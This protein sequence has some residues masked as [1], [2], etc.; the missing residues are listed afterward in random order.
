MA[1]TCVQSVGTTSGQSSQT[2]FLAFS[3]N[4]TAGNLLIV[5]WR[6]GQACNSV[7]DTLGNS[8]TVVYDQ[9]DGSGTHGGWA[10]AFSG[11]SGANTVT[12]HLTASTAGNVIAVAEYNGPNTFRAASTVAIGST[13]SLVT[14][15][16]T[17]TAGDLLIAV[18]ETNA[19]EPS[20]PTIAGGVTNNRVQGFAAGNMYVNIGDNLSATGGSTTATW[21]YGSGSNVTAGIGAFYAAY[22]VS[23]NAGVAGATVSYSGTASGSVTADGS[24]NYSIPGLG[25]GSYTITPSKTGYSFSPVSSNQT[26]AGANITGVNFVATASG[27]QAGVLSSTLCSAPVPAVITDSV[28]HA[29]LF[30]SP[31][32]GAKLGQP[33][34]VCFT[35]GSG[36]EL[37]VQGAT[38][39]GFVS[40]PVPVTLV[41]WNGTPIPA[42]FVLT[43]NGVTITFSAT[44][45]G[46]QLGAPTPVGITDPNGFEYNFA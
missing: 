23:G 29:L 40:A 32:T 2:P 19:A 43:N 26:V 41:D 36:N 21:S 37:L 25:N 3:S 12:L 14:N 6:T 4:V 17:A 44:L 30:S 9:A 20:T 11:S 8:W 15:A 27:G 24:G 34:P 38:L 7:T 10:Y 35:D 31:V 1:N 33:T 22:A 18:L 13:T 39:G 45:T 5:S 16:V 46:K 28:G 42:P